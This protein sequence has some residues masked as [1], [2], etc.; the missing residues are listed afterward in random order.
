MLAP[1]AA[2]GMA[3][4]WAARLRGEGGFSKI[5]A[6]KSMLPEL[7]DEPDYRTMFLDE[8]RV[9]SKLRHPNVCETFDLGEE[10]GALFMAMEWI[11]GASLHRVFKPSGG[12]VR[13]IPV[14]LAA[15]IIAHAS[16]GLHAAHEALEDDGTPLAIVHRDVSPQNVL[17]SIDGHVKVTDFGIAAARGQRHA[18]RAGQA[19]GKLAYMA[20]EQL[21]GRPVDRRADVFALGCVLYEIT[22]GRKAFDGRTD[23]DVYRAILERTPQ[24][25]SAIVA[26]YPEELERIVARA[27]AKDPNERFATADGL[28]LALERWL[29]SRGAR[30]SERDIAALVQD[31]CGDEIANVRACIR[32]ESAGPPRPGPTATV[33][34]LPRDAKGHVWRAVVMVLGAIV[35]AGG[36]ASVLVSSTSKDADAHASITAKTAARESLGPSAAITT[37]PTARLPAAAF[38][39]AKRV[40]LR[41]EPANAHVVLDGE[42]LELDG[43]G[44]AAIDRPEDGGMSVGVVKAAGFVDRLFVIDANS[45]EAVEVT[46]AASAPAAS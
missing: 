34:P 29:A 15:R 24:R 38:A 35:I 6:I 22:T 36:V 45:P 10:N 27:L 8:A 40:T 19:K 3:S 12:V 23:H 20:P 31:R 44:S 32:S 7:A 26:D 1:I 16:A 30:T 41:F 42:P 5:V 21:R 14:E 17:L 39:G 2:G 37:A 9:A 4:V 25:S 18:T 33:R 13:P 43:E 28:R 46:L 11:D